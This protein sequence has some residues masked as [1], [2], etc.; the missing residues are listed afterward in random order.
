MWI[1]DR[2]KPISLEEVREQ[3]E[4]LRN[5]KAAGLDSILPEMLKYGKD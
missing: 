1:R 5:G 3:R 4:K 2:D